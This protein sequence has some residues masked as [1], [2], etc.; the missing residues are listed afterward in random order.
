LWKAWSAPGGLQAIMPK[1]DGLA[2]MVSAIVSRE[3]GFGVAK[4]GQCV[5]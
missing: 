4:Q 3:F 1:D 5:L 2:V